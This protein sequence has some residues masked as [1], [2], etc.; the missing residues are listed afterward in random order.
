MINKILIFTL[1]TSLI[2]SAAELVNCF[3]KYRHDKNLKNT[4]E[5]WL[6]SVVLSVLICAAIEL[7]K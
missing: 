5:F 4:L 1:F 7:T 6:S 2:L 3:L